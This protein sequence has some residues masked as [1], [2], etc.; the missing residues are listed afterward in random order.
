M[1]KEIIKTALVSALNL[2]SSELE[3]VCIEELKDE[4]LQAILKIENGLRELEN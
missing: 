3:S 1:E 2:I 4:Y